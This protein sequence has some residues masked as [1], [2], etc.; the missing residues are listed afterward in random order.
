MTRSIP[1]RISVIDL[2]ADGYAD[3]MY[4]ADL[5]GQIWRF[6]IMQDETPNNLVAGGVI[7]QLGA[8]GLTNPSA[9]DTRRFYT[10]PD[11]SMFEDKR[12]QRRYLA[13]SIG[14]GYRAHPLDNSASDVFYSLRDPDV[15]R[16]LSQTEYNT[17]SIIRNS[18]LVEVSGQ[19]DTVISVF[20]R[21]WKLTLP[22]EQKVLS[23]SRTFNDLLY[24][25]SLQPEVDAEDPCRAGLSTNRLYRVQVDNG[26]PVWTEGS[27]V[28]P[29]GTDPEVIDDA[30]V[31]DLEQSGIAPAPVFLFP[32]HWDPDC[33]GDE[34]AT[35][36]MA[37]VGVECFDPDFDN[38]P[39]R[40]LWNQD[41]IY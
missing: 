15:F 35:R 1:S 34:C 8:E 3:R 38:V 40:T 21:G 22:P 37:C 29:V 27:P 17:Y 26:D 36:P 41:G 24:F 20:D 16:Q 14:S 11:V 6:D 4:A 12:Q 5:G 9:A 25:V 10:S 30:R 13:V 19:H 32:S 7:A 18:D 28:P 31:A 2:T 23:D 33:V 39:V